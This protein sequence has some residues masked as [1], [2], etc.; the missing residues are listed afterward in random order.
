MIIASPTLLLIATLVSIFAVLIGRRRRIG[1]TM[2]TTL[3]SI[4]GMALFSLAAGD[5]ACK[6]SQRPK[7]AVMVDVSPS[8]RGAAYRVNQAL[9]A[10][11]GELLGGAAYE[12]Y[13]FA[14][15]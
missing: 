12:L 11:I 10:R 3:F 1:L 5:I 15:E 2:L 8:T 14:D 6:W 7:I 13:Q 4:L 9:S